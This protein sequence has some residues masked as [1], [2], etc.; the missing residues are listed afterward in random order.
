VLEINNLKATSMEAVADMARLEERIEFL[1][2]PNNREQALEATVE[3]LRG[4][5]RQQEREAESLSAQLKSASRQRQS[6]RELLDWGGMAAEDS[7]AQIVRECEQRLRSAET[8]LLCKVREARELQQELQ[9][10]EVLKRMVQRSE[11]HLMAHEDRSTK[12]ANLM[13]RVLR[14]QRVSPLRL[15]LSSL[16]VRLSSPLSP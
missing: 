3:Q 8:A 1:S 10:M 5:L 12:S 14:A 4:E 2:R 7:V 6:Y 13:A 11:Q 16:S 15:F 9:E